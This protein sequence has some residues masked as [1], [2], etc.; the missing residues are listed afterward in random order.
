[1]GRHTQ[2]QADNR[3]VA[4][5]WLDI[6]EHIRIGADDNLE[7]CECVSYGELSEC[8]KDKVVIVR[9]RILDGGN[10]MLDKQVFPRGCVV[11]I[12]PLYEGPAKK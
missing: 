3:N 10:L 11:A 8:T 2:E 1:M 7:P 12:V 9:E 4:V 6:T 5:Y